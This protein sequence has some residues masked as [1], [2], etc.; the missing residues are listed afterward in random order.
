[1]K[2]SLSRSRTI[3]NVEI[4]SLYQP[5]YS[6]H[7]KR[8]IGVE[9]LS[10]G[11]YR[12]QPLD[13]VEL[14]SL[15][16]NEKEKLELNRKCIISA[17]RNVSNLPASEQYTVFINFDSSL[18]DNAAFNNR[19]FELGIDLSAIT[20]QRI[21]VELIESR[22]KDFD[23]LLRFTAYCRELGFLIALDDVG[24]GYSSLERM[25]KIKPDIIKIDRSLINGVSEEFYKREA[26]RALVKLS[27]NIGAL[28]L[29]EGVETLQDA[30]EC[31]E[32]GA[33]ILQG[34]YFSKPVEK[35]LPVDTTTGKISLLVET[36]NF[37]ASERD[38][39]LRATIGRVKSQAQIIHKAL[40]KKSLEEWNSI[41]QERVE[42]M[43]DIEC[44]YILD[45]YGKQTSISALRSNLKYKEHYLF[46]PARPGADHSQKYYYLR[47]REGETWY[48]SDPYISRATGNICRTVSMM[49]ETEE[50]ETCLL[51][52]DIIAFPA[53]V[54]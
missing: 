19:D 2:F 4:R 33:D 26:C 39:I 6:V 24:A 43:P 54:W 32:M 29:A 35:I 31:Q 53:S 1:M 5:L 42:T 51:C 23:R 52:L 27:H 15:P 50:S 10:R 16:N 30:L 3:K 49:F 38:K 34:F 11:T 12:G 46:K 25:V 37:S 17:L 14:F 13:A 9:A 28:S 21:V 47:R 20:P 41:L 7:E 8:Y 45:R 36:W 44:A 18:M 22:V 40:M 48:I